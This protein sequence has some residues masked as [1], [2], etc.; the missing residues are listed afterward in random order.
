MTLGMDPHQLASAAMELVRT[1]WT[2]AAIPVADGALK[3]AGKSLFTLLTSAFTSKAAA[4]T[5]EEAAENPA[6]LDKAEALEIQIKNAITANPQFAGNVRNLIGSLP[7]ES[8]SRI[9]QTASQT[10]DKNVNNQVTGDSNKIST[11]IS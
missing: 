3:E 2:A 5:L 7:E 9:I 6:D 1:H 11:K 4:A 8:R 10:G